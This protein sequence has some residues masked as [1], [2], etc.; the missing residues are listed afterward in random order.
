MQTISNITVG[1]ADI[2]MS[3]AS[4]VPGVRPG[5]KPGSLKRQE[6]ME[7]EGEH[8]RATPRRSTGINPK[9]RQAI[10]PR[11]PLLSPP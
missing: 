9:A 2:S 3:K 11:S 1:K 4:H 5:N 10:D 6:G 8:V 7:L